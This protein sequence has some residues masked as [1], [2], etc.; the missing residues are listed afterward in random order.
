MYQ[1]DQGKV[2]NKFEITM[3]V[4]DSVDF[5]IDPVKMVNAQTSGNLATIPI[6]A[7]FLFTNIV[8]T[9]PFCLKMLVFVKH[10]T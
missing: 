10:Q 9:V 1:Q 4:G 5:Q 2:T 8:T 7:E 6:V 3:M